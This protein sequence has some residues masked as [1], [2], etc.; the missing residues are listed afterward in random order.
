MKENLILITS[1]VL[2]LVISLSACTSDINLEEELESKNSTIIELEQRVTELKTELNKERAFS[3]DLMV[4]AI[5]VVNLI[6]NKDMEELTSYIHPTAGVRFSPYEYI[7][8]KSHRVFTADEIERLLDDE[9]VYTWGNYDGSGKP[10]E[11]NFTNYYDRFIYDVDFA[12]PNMLGNNVVIGSGNTINNI[13][14]AY[15]DG[16]F[17]EFHFKGIE[18]QYKGMDW[19][20]LWL[21]F[22][23]YDGE[24]YLVGIVHGEWTI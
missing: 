12:D 17:I 18:P 15:P 6:K 16:D 20:S 2:M 3:N 10:I 21:V 7:D 4:K 1:L 14:E 5:K 23:E 24:W 9:Q 8:I 19:R 22:E 13:E 11:L